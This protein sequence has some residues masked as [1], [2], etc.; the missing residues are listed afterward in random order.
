[1]GDGEERHVVE[2]VAK[3]L[4]NEGV[5]LEVDGRG[6]LVDEEE[7]RSPDETSSERDE[8]SGA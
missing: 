6:G 5:R 3:S 8:L 1:M 7:A 2:L 4:L